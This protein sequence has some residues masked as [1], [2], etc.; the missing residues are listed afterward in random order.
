[1]FEFIILLQPAFLLYVT[2]QKTRFFI[3]DEIAANVSI[4]FFF[5]FGSI[6][7]LQKNEDIAIPNFCKLSLLSVV[8]FIGNI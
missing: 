5:C 1:M 4:R 6:I 8:I 2:T 3:D 7:Q